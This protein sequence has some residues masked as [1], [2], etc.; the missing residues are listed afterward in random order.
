MNKNVLRMVIIAFFAAVICVTGFFKVPVPGIPS[1]IVLQNAVC[2]LTA[3]L[4]GG[5]L[6]GSPAVLFTVVGL[7]GVPIYAGWIGGFSLLTNVSG[8]FRIGFAFGAVVAGVI[9][10]KASVEDRRVSAPYA[11][12]ISLAVVAGMI[13]VY[14]PEIFYVIHFYSGDVYTEATVARLGLDASL[15]GQPVGT[16]G[17]MKVF[18]GMFFLPFMAGD[19]IKSVVAVLLALK[20][21]P[22][23]A[24]YFYG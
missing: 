22:V 15:V 24:Q 3:V 6:G 5:F 23:V 16:A 13:A 19:L 11:V 20:I 2:I 7:L 12:R 14:V 18:F 9:A 10:G 21:R 1:G 17:A 8:G 4:I